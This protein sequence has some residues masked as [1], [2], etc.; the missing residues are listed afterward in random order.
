MKWKRE[1]GGTER[2]KEVRG[3][4][5][6]GG[7]RGRGVGGGGKLEGEG[8]CRGRGVGRRESKEGGV[9][10]EGELEGEESSAWALATTCVACSTCVYDDAPSNESCGTEGKGGVIQSTQTATYSGNYRASYWRC[11][12]VMSSYWL[13]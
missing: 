3:V 11:G 2:R 1:T 7:W 12:P 6:E 13:S 5:R 4:E 9:R 10:N 8:N